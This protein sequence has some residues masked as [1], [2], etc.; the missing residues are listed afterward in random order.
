MV[1]GTHYFT[2]EF[3]YLQGSDLMLAYEKAGGASPIK[4]VNIP[5][6]IAKHLPKKWIYVESHQLSFWYVDPEQWGYKYMGDIEK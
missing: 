6:R 3:N 1:Q 4:L 2:E 5:Y